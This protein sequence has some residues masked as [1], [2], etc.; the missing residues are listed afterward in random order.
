MSVDIFRTLAFILL[1]IGA[2]FVA[3]AVFD[4]ASGVWTAFVGGG[5][6]SPA[7]P[8]WLT[9]SLSCLTGV[10]CLAGAFAQMVLVSRQLRSTR[11][12]E[13]D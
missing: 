8:M 10:L 13:H 1:A 3:N 12:S 6:R 5:G 7:V 9:F 2:V 11:V 4:E